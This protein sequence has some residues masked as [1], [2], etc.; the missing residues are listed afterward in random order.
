MSV[1]VMGGTVKPLVCWVHVRIGLGS[2]VAWP[3]H[4]SLLSLLGN[5]WVVM[6]T[7]LIMGGTGRFVPVLVSY[8]Q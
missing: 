2:F 3:A 8:A 5:T 4:G 1:R 6:L 7:V